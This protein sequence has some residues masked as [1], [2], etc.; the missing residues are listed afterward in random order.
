MQRNAFR[1]QVRAL[2]RENTPGQLRETKYGSSYVGRGRGLYQREVVI[3]D[4]HQWLN[5]DKQSNGFANGISPNTGEGYSCDSSR[6]GY[7]VPRH[8]IDVL[9]SCSSSASSSSTSV[10]SALPERTLHAL[11]AHALKAQHSGEAADEHQR[12]ICKE[13][14]HCLSQ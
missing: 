10:K 7:A 8:P 3:R 13:V 2:D 11:Y 12:T 5:I 6:L 14:E 1:S 4:Q 9:R